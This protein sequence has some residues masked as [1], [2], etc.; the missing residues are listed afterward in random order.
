MSDFVGHYVYALKVSSFVD[1]AATCDGTHTGYWRQPCWKKGLTFTCN[2]QIL[3]SDRIIFIIPNKFWL[4]KC[5]K[6]LVILFTVLHSLNSFWAEPLIIFSGVH[7]WFACFPWV[8]TFWSR[9]AII[10]V[11]HQFNYVATPIGCRALCQM[12]A[13]RM[14]I[15]KVTGVILSRY[16]LLNTKLSLL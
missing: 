14:V 13:S 5:F 7:S 16:K 15:A 2:R 9:N 10:M 3:K 12:K 1:S 4:S 8:W 6:H 11:S